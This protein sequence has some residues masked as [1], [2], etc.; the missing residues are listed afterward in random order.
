MVT[1][2]SLIRI[3]LMIAIGAALRFAFLG[4]DGLWLDEGYTAWTVDLPAAQHRVALAN[5][6]APPLYYAVQRGLVPHLPR[7]ETS[8][9]LLSAAFGVAGVA[10]LAACPPSAIALEAPAAFFAVGPYGVAY[11]RQARSYA[12]LLFLEIVLIAATARALQG[13]RRW[14][15]IVAVSEGLALWTHNV[16]TTL[17]VGANLAWILGGRRDARGWITAQAGALL[18]WLPY[19]IRMAPQIRMH[20]IENG[21]I[22]SYWHHYP[23]ALASLLSIG[24]MAAG[25]RVWPPPPTRHWLYAGPGSIVISLLC[26]ASVIVL[27]VAAFKRPTRREAILA[28][29]FTLGPLLALEAISFATTPSYLLGR[30]DAVA[31]VG[32][33]IRWG[34][35]GVLSISAALALA[36]NLPIGA[37]SHRNDRTIG[38]RLREEIRPGDW[39]AFVG[40]SRCSI[41][42]YASGGRPG[43]P[44][45]AV[46]RLDYPARFGKNPSATYPTPGESLRVWEKEAYRVRERFE[47][48]SL[49]GSRFYYV[50][51]VNP[52][53]PR[54]LSAED[55][56]YP[57]ALLAYTLNGKRDIAPIARL[58]G[59]G[60]GTDWIVF[61]VPRDSLVSLDQLQP[62][63]ATP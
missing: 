30:T 10:V 50:G 52:T 46:R 34:I 9:R 63:E 17:V 7:S 32:R 24:Y 22:A 29:S 60:L 19:L 58:R 31:Y 33:R 2:A 59:D 12:L 47:K 55:L 15:I 43:R 54:D 61:R 41:D 13:R 62:V 26:V 53:A 6:D 27:L 40:L 5:D 16:A 44:D 8:L 56:P 21:W 18:V 37:H 36:M 42:Y 11:G 45:P 57:G 39:I 23:L 3:A 48:E 1:R 35:L 4:S 38:T 49:P 28:A 20:E 14:L 25:A 51:A